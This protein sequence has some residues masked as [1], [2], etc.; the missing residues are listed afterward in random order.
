ML[1]SVVMMLLCATTTPTPRSVAVLPLEAATGMDTKTAQLLTDVIT[2]E[3]AK[4]T[5]IKVIGAS[6]VRN[7]ISFEQ[8]RSMLGCTENSC[9]AEIGAALGVDA[10]VSGSIGQLG[11]SSIL[12]LS[13]VDIKNTSVLGRASETVEGSPEQLLPLIPFVVGTTMQ[14]IPG[15]PPPPPR[16]VQQTKASAT[17][18]GAAS[19]P[20]DGEKEDGG[21]PGSLPRRLAGLGV[22]GLGAVVL[23]VGVGLGVASLGYLVTT[24]LEA[25]QET[26]GMFPLRVAGFA[27]AGGA[28]ALG[29]I[30]VLVMLGGVVLAALP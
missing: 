22:V 14:G 21:G 26:L 17:K 19:Q 20:T 10:I 2:A 27:V 3:V 13:L 6:E 12:N 15:G 8:Q 16:P 4:R 5:D 11:A 24:K 23:L 29:V 30:G 1:P 7:L 18:A 28:D 25:T 9:L